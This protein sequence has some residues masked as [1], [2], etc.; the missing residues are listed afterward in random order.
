M[1]GVIGEDINTIYLEIED[2]FFNLIEDQV[3]SLRQYGLNCSIAQLT[4]CFGASYAKRLL[5][6]RRS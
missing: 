5:I 2:V 1:F 4:N 6:L 3:K